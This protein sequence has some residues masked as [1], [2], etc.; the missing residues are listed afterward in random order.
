MGCPAHALHCM[1]ISR[2]SFSVRA[3]Q[4]VNQLQFKILLQFKT[5]KRRKIPRRK[6]SIDRGTDGCDLGQT[7]AETLAPG[8]AWPAV[9]LT[10]DGFDG[11]TEGEVM[12]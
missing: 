3:S 8:P 4:R 2:S 1:H 12:M 7:D 6:S 11:L 10:M 9:D 5:N